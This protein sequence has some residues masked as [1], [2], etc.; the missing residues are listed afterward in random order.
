MFHSIEVF[1]QRCLEM[2]RVEKKQNR[3]WAKR[4]HVSVKCYKEN[5]QTL[6]VL[7]KKL[8]Q[9]NEAATQQQQQQ[10][11]ENKNC[12]ILNITAAEQQPEHQHKRTNLIGDDDEDALPDLDSRM[13]ADLVASSAQKTAKTNDESNTQAVLN[14]LVD[15]KMME[16]LKNIK[17][18]TF[19]CSKD[20]LI[21]WENSTLEN[22]RILLTLAPAKWALKMLLDEKRIF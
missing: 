10:Q 16:S 4:M 7:E 13:C 3:L 1:I 2:M 11:E 8:A 6:F 22:S 20:V 21:E 14:K 19:C 12:E 17:G 15:K 5:M 18:L 9:L